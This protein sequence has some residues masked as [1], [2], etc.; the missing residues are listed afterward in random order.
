MTVLRFVRREMEERQAQSDTH[1]RDILDMM[2]ERGVLPPPSAAG[3]SA[4]NREDPKSRRSSNRFHIEPI[5]TC[6]GD[7]V[8]PPFGVS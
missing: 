7:I 4:V 6:K 8:A 5:R 1:S 2:N 3:A